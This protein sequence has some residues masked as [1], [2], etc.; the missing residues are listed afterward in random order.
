MHMQNKPQFTFRG[1]WGTKLDNERDRPGERQRP[2]VDEWLQEP[3]GAIG[4]D[5][6]ARWPGQAPRRA[7]GERLQ[8]RG[9]ARRRELARGANARPEAPRRGVPVSLSCGIVAERR[10]VVAVGAGHEIA[11]DPGAARD[12]AA[13]VDPRLNAPRQCGNGWQNPQC[14]SD[15][16]ARV[17]SLRWMGSNKGERRAKCRS[18]GLSPR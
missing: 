9:D 4:A 2:R 5:A 16:G 17:E 13:D 12:P 10:G 14:L 11:D 7:R 8:G 18:D 1:S 3:A 6:V 15:G